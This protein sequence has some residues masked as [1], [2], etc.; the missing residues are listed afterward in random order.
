MKNAPASV[1]RLT[2]L[3]RP[4]CKD[5]PGLSRPFLPKGAVVETPLIKAMLDY[6]A[7]GRRRFTVPG[8]AGQPLIVSPPLAPFSGLPAA[9]FQYD[10][11]EVEGLDVLSEPDGCLQE[12]QQ[13][14]AEAVGVA[15]SYFLVNGSTVGLMAAML[16]GLQPGDAV[17]LPRNV[18]RS[19]L[20]G[21]ILT[22]AVPIWFLPPWDAHWGLWQGISSAQ[23]E[24]LLEKHPAV[25]AL[26]LPSPTYEGVGSEVAALSRLCRERNVLLFIDEA[27]GSL[28]PFCDQLPTSA[29]VLPVDGVVQSFH[30]TGG[31]LTQSAM[32]H[33]PHR[34]RLCPEAFQQALNT[35]Q[36]TS[37]SY[38]LLASLDASRAYLSAPVGQARIEALLQHVRTLRSGFDSNQS[39]FELYHP[40]EAA[41]PFWDPTRLYVRSLVESGETWTVR[42]EAERQ[43][44]YEAASPYGGLYVAGLGLEASDFQFFQAAFEAEARVMRLSEQ[45]PWVP[46]CPALPLPETSLSPREAFFAQGVRLESA[47]AVGRVAK[48][49]VVHCPPG[50]AVVI[51]GE[52]IQRD[53]LPYLP[54]TVQVVH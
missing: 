31:S 17:L 34:S 43:L 30:K 2:R 25:K 53:H 45:P 32:A 44:T 22:G 33:L 27:H 1:S 54:K 14:A 3:V 40:T 48:E 20:S 16:A 11:T 46:T 7:L 28:W 12:A 4:R 49:T 36:T 6:E 26:I 37:P 24:D 8:H 51:P 29:C 39:V 41:A 19:V 50:I 23:V 42:M 15:H 35:L 47:Q 21:L 13:A 10:Q 52:V 5:H 9:A 38:L 18:H